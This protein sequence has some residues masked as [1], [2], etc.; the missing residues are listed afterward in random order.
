MI[1]QRKINEVIN[2]IVEN[3]NPEKI[4]LFGSYANKNP[5][6]HS[7]LDLLVIKD[8]KLPRYKR[9][10]EVR[11]YFWRSM[12]PIDIVIYTNKEFNEDKDLRFTFIN[13]V[14]KTG[15]VVYEK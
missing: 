9:G 5:N 13:N 4:I 1:S 12:I 7:D 10:S 2:K 3:Y 14:L 11:K 6:E 8:T 15:K